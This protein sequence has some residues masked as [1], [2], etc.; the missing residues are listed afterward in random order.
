MPTLASLQH[1]E[2]VG[3]IQAGRQGLGSQEQ[4]WWPRAQGKS[5]RE[6]VAGE[7]RSVEEH[8]RLTNL[9]AVGLSKQGAWTRWEGWSRRSWHGVTCGRW[10]SMGF[11][12]SYVRYTTSSLPLRISPN[13]SFP[14]PAVV[15]CVRGVD[16][17]AHSQRLPQSSGT[18]NVH[19]EALPGSSCHSEGSGEGR[20][21][22][23][24]RIRREW[25][26]Q[27]HPFCVRRMWHWPESWQ[28]TEESQDPA[29]RLRLEGRIWPIWQACFPSCGSHYTSPPWPGHMVRRCQ[30]PHHWG[31]HRSMGRT[32][33]GSKR[34]QEN[35]VRPLMTECTE[36]QWQVH[37]L[38]FEVGCRGFAGTCLMT[39]L[40]KLGITHRERKFV[41]NSASNAALRASTWIW[42]KHRNGP[43]W[44]HQA[45]VRSGSGVI[46]LVHLPTSPMCYWV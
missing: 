41:C 8:K 14:T 1:K 23:K 36:K 27:I 19:L 4:V 28:A 5:R 15:A 46:A 2:I 13:G 24:P 31:T 11:L 29:R 22:C 6:L 17:A 10:S 38:P 16:T 21:S 30:S 42:A 35:Q 43:S 20:R 45:P 26:G 9:K 18:G 25:Q 7:L 37:C 44:C 40:H 3:A 39:F 32:H 33:E 34:A 12:S